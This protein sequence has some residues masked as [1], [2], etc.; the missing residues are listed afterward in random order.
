MSRI[1][2]TSHLDLVLFLNALVCNLH[3][4]NI[5]IDFFELFHNIF[6]KSLNKDVINVITYQEK[7]EGKEN[8][9]VKEEHL[10]L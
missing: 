6:Q 3:H 7:D 8:T 9:R 4:G 5:Q 2:H 10:M 1:I